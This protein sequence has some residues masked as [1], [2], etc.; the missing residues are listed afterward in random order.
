LTKQAQDRE[1]YNGEQ[2]ATAEYRN[3]VIQIRS[4]RFDLDAKKGLIEQTISK[5]DSYLDTFIPKGRRGTSKH[6][7][8]G[9]AGKLI[10]MMRSDKLATKQALIGQIVSIH[11]NTGNR[12]TVDGTKRLEEAV[13][14]ILR[15]MADVPKTKRLRV[16]SEIDYGL[17]FTRKRKLLEYLDDMQKRWT[18]FL[19]DKY[20]NN[21]NDLN[22]A[23]GLSDQTDIKPLADFQKLMPPTMS[24]QRKVSNLEQ[25]K[26]DIEEFRNRARI[27]LVEEEEELGEGAV[28]EETEE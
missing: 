17:Y 28:G 26:R 2:K 20:K 27:E 10:G 16:L 6:S 14:S 7:L 4:E 3:T 11:E 13:E 15:T 18:K 24:F 21:I 12:I 25:A 9:P 23:W 19:Q 1:H 22:M 5:L 8:L